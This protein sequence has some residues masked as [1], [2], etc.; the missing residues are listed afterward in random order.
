MKSLF[1]FSPEPRILKYTESNLERKKELI[2]A[3]EASVKAKK[4]AS[5]SSV[6]AASS[7]ATAA[8]TAAATG[9]TAGQ[10]RKAT[11]EAA[12]ETVSAA[13]PAPSSHSDTSKS[14]KVRVLIGISQYLL[15][16]EHFIQHHSV[17][18]VLTYYKLCVHARYTN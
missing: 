7:A 1:C 10:K 6:A 5:H 18:F 13:S 15:Q 12:G 9:S 17:T 4:A 2:K 14:P 3:H 11:S 16:S 8:G